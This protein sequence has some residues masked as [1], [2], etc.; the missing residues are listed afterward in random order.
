MQRQPHLTFL[1]LQLFKRKSAFLQSKHDNL[2]TLSLSPALSLSL[3]FASPPPLF[4]SLTLFP[5]CLFLFFFF[6]SQPHI[7]GHSSCSYCYHHLSRLYK[8]P[9][10]LWE[11][12]LSKEVSLSQEEEAK[13][14]PK[15]EEPSSSGF[16]F[17][18]SR[19]VQASTICCRP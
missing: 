15:E 18:S 7:H 12:L 19:D 11:G 10:K 5:F 8:L 9:F 13:E 4:S 2:T 1:V 17:I 14:A 6:S 16:R 3:Y